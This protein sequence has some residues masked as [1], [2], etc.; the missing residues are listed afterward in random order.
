M[1]KKFDKALMKLYIKNGYSN[2]DFGYD[3][4]DF[5][6]KVPNQQGYEDYFSKKN[7]INFLNKM[8]ENPKAY[9]AYIKGG[10]SETIEKYSKK[11]GVWY[12]PKMASVA[13]SSRFI[14]NT[15]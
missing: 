8:K 6:N 9:N 4:L 11:Y 13:S 2:E 14:G 12:P 5:D 1:K 7:W 15:F 3:A 10:G